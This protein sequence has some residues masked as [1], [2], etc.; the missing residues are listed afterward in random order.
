MGVK[1]AWLLPREKGLLP[2]SQEKISLVSA[3]SKIRVDVCA[4]HYT[5]IRRIYNNLADPDAAYAKLEQWLVKDGNKENTR[6]YVD[7][8]PALEKQQTHA[9]RHQCRQ[10]ALTKANTAISDLETRL[11]TNKRIR[12]HHITKA[13]KHLLQGFHW[14]LRAQRVVCRVHDQ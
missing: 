7:G 11:A 14:S 6:F 8:K 13:Y 3:E 1:Y 4:T 2:E 10:N 9:D 5:S 12:K